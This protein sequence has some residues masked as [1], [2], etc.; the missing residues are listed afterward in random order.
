MTNNYLTIRSLFKVAFLL[1][2]S[3]TMQAQSDYT[4]S[5]IPYQVYTATAAV[6]GTNDDS[7]SVPIPL[8]FSFD[9]YGSTYNQV[10]ISTNGYIAFA[11]AGFSP[12]QFSTSI[13]DAGFPVKNAFL[14]CFHDINNSNAEGTITYSI[15]GTA[16]YR[17]LVVLFNNQSHLPESLTKPD[18]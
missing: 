7:L 9:F 8:G 10:W 16:P 1:V 15:L 4:V 6:Q 2:F 5:P 13:P 17:K 12:W 11:D 14:G 3:T 18:Y